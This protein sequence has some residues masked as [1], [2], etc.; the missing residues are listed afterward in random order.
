MMTP[1]CT[2]QAIALTLAALFLTV[3]GAF[4]ETIAPG[5]VRVVE[6]TVASVDVAHRAVV[7]AAPTPKGEL[8]VGVTLAAGVEPARNG[9][10]IPL[11]DVAVGERAVLR[12]SR[13][14]GRL[15]G[16]ALTVRR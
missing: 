10:T 13:E 12:Y 7:V 4:A 5:Q 8:T 11:S 3:P 6:G 2:L 1:R 16:L 9:S 14:D 15:V